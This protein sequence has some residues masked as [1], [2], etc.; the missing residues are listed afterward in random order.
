MLS[1]SL[2]S[3]SYLKKLLLVMSF[4]VE[5]ILQFHCLFVILALTY[6]LYSHVI[7]VVIVVLSVVEMWAMCG[8]GIGIV[9]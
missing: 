6:L 8:C 9:V 3:Y 1:L 4:I 2:L 7:V 5:L